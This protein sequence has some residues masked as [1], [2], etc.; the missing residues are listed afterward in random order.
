MVELHRTGGGVRFLV[1]DDGRG[2]VP[3]ASTVSSDGGYG[4]H[5]MR[6]R[7]EMV[8]GELSVESEPGRG[9]RVVIDLPSKP[10]KIGVDA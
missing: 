2:F 7:T 6:E 4:L 3:G 10:Q 9:T 1:T 5:T 8:G